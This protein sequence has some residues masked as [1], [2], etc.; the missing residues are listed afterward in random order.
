MSK[1]GPIG[2]YSR[3]GTSYSWSAEDMSIEPAKAGTANNFAVLL[4]L[5]RG[6][7]WAKEDWPAD[8]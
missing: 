1:R 7:F 4:V 2:S 5:A 6:G 8:G 3:P